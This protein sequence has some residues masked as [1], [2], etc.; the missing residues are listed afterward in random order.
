VLDQPRSSQRYQVTPPDGEA[1][2]LKEILKLVRQHPRFG[3]RRIG[4]MLQAAGWKVN[5]KRIYRLWRREGLKV[6]RKQRKKRSLGTGENACHRRQPERKNHVW[7][8]DFIFD[9]T[10]AGST[11]KWL[12]I[13]DEYTRECLALQVD[14]HITSEHVI[15]VLAELFKT[16]GVPEYIRS[17]NG[18]EFVSQAIRAWLK[19][20]GVETLYIEPASPWENGYAESFHSRVRDEFM[21]CEIF[22]NLKSARK[23]TAAWKEQYNTVRPHSSLGYRTPREFSEQCSSSRRTTSAFQ[24]N[25]AET[26]MLS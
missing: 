6:P 22:E 2:L 10:E 19:R 1:A 21:N 5:L 20:I 26:P 4:R 17:D 16:H 24:R 15:D 18:S 14:R 12:T 7:C 9:R 3:Y 25:T 8:W 13:L 23:Q 11:L